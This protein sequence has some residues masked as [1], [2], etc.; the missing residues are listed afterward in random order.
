MK[1]LL[2]KILLQRRARDEGFTLPIVIALGLIMTLLGLVNIISASEENLN[3]ISRNSSTD[4]LAVAEIGVAR[5]RE[6]LDT[7]R[8]LALYNVYTNDANVSINRWTGVGGVT[9]AANTYGIDSVCSTDVANFADRTAWHDVILSEA[10]ARTDFNRDG[11]RV[12]T[13]NMGQYR[14]V[15]YVYDIDGNLDNEDARSITIGATNLWVANFSQIDDGRNDDDNVTFNDT[16]VARYNPRGVLTVQGRTE[17]NGAV[18]QIEVEIPIKINQQDMNNLAPALWIGSGNVGSLGNLTIADGADADTISDTN[19]V[20]TSRAIPD[21]PGT[22]GTPG[23]A[24]PADQLNFRTGVTNR[25]ISDPRTVPTIQPIIDIINF[26]K[27]DGGN[28]TNS[29]PI[30]D[31][32]G[33]PA[34]SSTPD[35]PYAR[36]TDNST[37]VDYDPANPTADWDCKNIREC[38][39]YYDLPS[40]TSI[41]TDTE[42]DGIAKTTLYIDGTLNINEDIGSGISSNY[43]EIYV[44]P[45]SA[46]SD[47]T[48]NSGGAGNTVKI[49]AL[50]HAPGS[51]LTV[52][53][54]GNVEINGSVWVNDFINTDGAAVTIDPDFTSTSSTA[55]DRSYE[56]YTTTSTRIP[57]PLTSSPTDWKT[58]EATP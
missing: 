6:L 50:I 1:L 28:Q 5:Y 8:V 14:L 58:Q 41:N 35:R 3:A 52:I 46:S 38:R 13:V 26:A 44:N 19:I 4:A 16:T 17:P 53:G 20:V 29:G 10:N 34:S 2:L 49:D 25:I 23:C 7:N 18:S 21:T 24:D 30:S 45:D 39:Y 32:L 33:R 56:F 31:L 27:T 22:P 12:D 9:G 54:T 37:F 42:T 36:Q 15:S 55:S 43:L 48:I 40:G 47:I 57:R 11:D 51:T